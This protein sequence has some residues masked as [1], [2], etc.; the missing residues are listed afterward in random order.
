MELSNYIN[1][2]WVGSKTSFRSIC[3][4][5]QSSLGTV[6]LA[7]RND[8]GDAIGSA[9]KAFKDWSQLSLGER[10]NYVIKASE[11]LAELYGQMG[12]I[13]PL[14]KI[15]NQEMGKRFPEADIEVI[16]SSDMLKFFAEQGPHCLSDKPIGLN[17]E[18]W[19]TKL[20]TIGFMPL[21]VVGIIKPWNYP[22][23][24]PL[25]SIGAALMAGNTIVFK[26]SELTPFVGEKIV[27]IFQSVN[28]PDGVFNMVCGDG[29]VGKYIVGHNDI[30]MISFTG[31]IPVGREIAV[32]CA[33]N[34]TRVS[35]ELGGK[36]SMI[37]LDDVDL[38]LAVNGALWGS[39]TNCGQVCVGVKRILVSRN[40]KDEFITKLARK[41][42]ELRLGTDIG[43]LV[44]KTQ[45]MKVENHVNQAV[46]LGAKVICGGSRPVDSNFSK[47]FYYLPTILVNTT[48]KMLVETE[49]TFGPVV[50]I[51]E[52]LN[53]D[54]AIE[55]A[56]NSSYDLGASIWTSNPEKSINLAKK[57]R[58]GMVWINDVNVAFPQA[59][60]CGHRWSGHGIEL[61]EFSMFEYSAIKHINLE[62]SNE[63]RRLWWFP[64]NS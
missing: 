58:T 37:I 4:E 17:R 19:P 40:I 31:S 26:P 53:E 38:E 16:E 43:P 32:R 35:L 46:R 14:K 6:S 60:W 7:S 52:F 51:K 44:S 27:E 45:L 13:T 34:S 12:E 63:N 28:L 59:P 48:S 42:E 64:Y 55:L 61:S 39:F 10:A 56:N 18:L 57:I 54:E 62:T 36:D 5:D 3:P 41:T 20:S 23:E 11:K 30:S 50:L 8:V 47:G 21:G 33:K 29:Q 1:G 49:D 25:W 22:L 9:K 2:K 24:L 15:I